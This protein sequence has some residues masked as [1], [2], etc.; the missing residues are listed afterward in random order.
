M[1]V[2]GGGLWFRAC[3]CSFSDCG[4]SSSAV[5]DLCGL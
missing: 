2:F 3:W 1:A 4:S 5:D